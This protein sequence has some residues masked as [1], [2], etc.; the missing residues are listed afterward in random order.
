M[1]SIR[2]SIKSGKSK[3]IINKETKLVKLNI[4]WVPSKRVTNIWWTKS[5]YET[6]YIP[7]SCKTNLPISVMISRYKYSNEHFI[8]AY[9][10]K[11]F[12]YFFLIEED[13]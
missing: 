7:Y 10:K 9:L 6:F 2:S 13:A 5:I 1:K 11:R 12:E 4:F 3:L 8:H